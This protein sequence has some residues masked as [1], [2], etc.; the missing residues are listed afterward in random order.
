[1]SSRYSNFQIRCNSCQPAVNAGATQ[2]AA[3]AQ[4]GSSAAKIPITNFGLVSND[5]IADFASRALFGRDDAYLGNNVFYI[6][7]CCSAKYI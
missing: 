5:Q 7:P 3:I 4:F 2:A 1:M 6:T